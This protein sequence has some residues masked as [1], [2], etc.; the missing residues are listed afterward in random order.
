MNAGAPIDGAL[1]PFRLDMRDLGSPVTAEATTHDPD[2]LAVDVPS[3]FEV[4]YG[5]RKSPFRSRLLAETRIFARSWHI[6]R[7]SCQSFLVKQL[8]IGSAIFFPPIDSAPVHYN[9][10]TM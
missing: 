8:A 4:I 3:V 10:W 2:A 1:Q 5:R 6:N 9:G 7:K